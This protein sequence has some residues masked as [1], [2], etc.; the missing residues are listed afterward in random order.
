[1]IK[2]SDVKQKNKYNFPVIQMVVTFPLESVCYK[3][4]TNQAMQNSMIDMKEA[5]TKCQ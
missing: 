2:I 4:P 5:C 1:M 3:I